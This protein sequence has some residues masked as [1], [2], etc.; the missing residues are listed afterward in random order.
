MASQL[1]NVIVVGGSYVGRATAQ[2]LARIIPTTHRV[3]L[4]EPHSHF[5]HLFAFPRYSV[6][7]GHEHK[8]F[9]PYTGVFNSLPNSSS[10]A[11]V[12]ARVLSVQPQYVKL[13]REW[14]GSNQI[15][16]EYLTIATGTTLAEPGT[17]KHDDKVSSVQYLQRHQEQVKKANSILIVGGGALGVQVA[18]DL[19]EYYLEKEVTLVHS[20]AQ[21]MPAFHPK[22]H[23]IVQKRFDEL[24]VKL[25]TGARVVVPSE[26]FSTDGSQYEVH[27]TNGTRL[28]ADFVIL[29]TGQKPNNDLLRDLIPSNG[30]S[31]ANPKNGFIRVRPTLQF[32]DSKYPNLFA[33]GDIADTGLHKAAK[34]GAA[35]AAV[36]ARN[37]QAMIE[38]KEPREHFSWS[39]AAIHL[40]LGLVKTEYSFPQSLWRAD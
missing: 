38:G 13:D 19:R 25:I 40:T 35:Q 11:V 5:H 28:T 29:A 14:Q 8:A 37:I 15:P 10:H 12:Q 34:P 18:T 26:R 39:P 31:L 24:G 17:I 4:I 36:A 32:L 7:P 27:L 9:I 6:V 2:E 33:V 30:E 23:D 3:L 22:I 1:K 16:F 21:V 20:R